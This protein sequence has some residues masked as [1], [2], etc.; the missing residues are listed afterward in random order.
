MLL[1]GM[2]NVRKRQLLTVFFSFI[3]H[4]LLQQC[5]SVTSLALNYTVRTFFTFITIHRV[6]PMP[7]QLFLNHETSP[8]DTVLVKFLFFHNFN[9]LFQQSLCTQD[10]KSISVQGVR[11]T[12]RTLLR[13]LT[14]QWPS[15]CGSKFFTQIS[16]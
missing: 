16:H 8:P 7:C 14:F 3:G 11:L 13:T 15:Y 2:T 5:Q 4:T 12:P 1:L 6:G 10:P 9:E